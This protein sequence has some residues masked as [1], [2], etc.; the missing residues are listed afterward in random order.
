MKNNTVRTVIIFSIIFNLLF[1][2]M[3]ALCIIYNFTQPYFSIFIT[4]FMFAY[5]F[6]IRLIV[7]F[8]CLVCFKNK[9]NVYSK[10][11]AVSNKEFKFLERLKVKSW[12]DKFFTWNKNMFVLQGNNKSD[13][14]NVL[15]HN[16]NSEITHI[17]CIIFSLL[18]ILF[19]CLLSIEEWWVY[20]LT[21]VI[22]LICFD[23]P[24]I[25]IQRYNR[26]RLYKILNR[27]K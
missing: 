14:E 25:L 21:A 22:A 13:I 20:L 9:F 23:V 15:K 6:D 12:K 27:L 2:T 24:P 7:S 10:T 19:G 18:S 5:H 1:F 11:Y 17:I 8:L 16:I 4:S 26:Y 3:L